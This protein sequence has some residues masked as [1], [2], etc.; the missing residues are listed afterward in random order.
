MADAGVPAIFEAAFQY[1]GIRARVDVLE[2]LSCGP[3]GQAGME[4]VRDFADL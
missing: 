3:W 4:L 1:D 2:R